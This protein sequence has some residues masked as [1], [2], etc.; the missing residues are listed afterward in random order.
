MQIKAATAEFLKI[1]NSRMPELRKA[2]RLA[3]DAMVVMRYL[4]GIYKLSGIIDKQLPKI[5]AGKEL[6]WLAK[7]RLKKAITTM[8]KIDPKLKT[9]LD[10]V[11]LAANAVA[12]VEAPE[13]KK[14]ATRYESSVR[15]FINEAMTDIIKELEIT[16]ALILKNQKKISPDIV[17]RIL[18][19]IEYS[20]IAAKNLE[21][22]KIDVGQDIIK[23]TNIALFGA[24][25]I[26]SLVI[27]I[28]YLARSA[29]QFLRSSVTVVTITMPGSYWVALAAV[30]GIMYTF[31]KTG[32]YMEHTNG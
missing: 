10:Y 30:I 18:I 7:Y 29:E 2:P 3:K 1:L 11:I 27:A 12:K 21:R 31:L 19:N 26:T 23:M 24:I 15:I 4:K 25:L 32:M 5:K 28:D 20:I 22:T 6:S 13:K 16:H 9:A 14:S 17:K 8:P